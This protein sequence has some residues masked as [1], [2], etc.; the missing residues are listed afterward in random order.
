M[1]LMGTLFST[2]LGKQRLKTLIDQRNIPPGE[3][4]HYFNLYLGGSVKQV[5][6]NYFLLPSVDA[7]E[8]LDEKYCD[9]FVVTSAFRDKLESLPTVQ[10]KDSVGLMQVC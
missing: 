8:A 2:L 4:I 3:R 9:P 1:S 7:Y 10:S 5:I 6:E